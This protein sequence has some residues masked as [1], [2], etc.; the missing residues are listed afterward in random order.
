MTGGCRRSLRASAGY[1]HEFNYPSRLDEPET[2]RRLGTARAH[3]DDLVIHP[4]VNHFASGLLDH[5]DDHDLTIAGG[6]GFEVGRCYFW[7]KLAASG[8]G[9]ER[10]RVDQLLSA[11]F[12]DVPAG[13][14][15]EALEMW[16]T[17]LDDE[18]P[19]DLDWRDRLYLEQRL[20]AWWST[21]NQTSDLIGA[22]YFYPANSLWIFARLLDHPPEAR[23]LGEPQKRVIQELSPQLARVPFNEAA[24]SVLTKSRRKIRAWRR[25]TVSK[26]RALAPEA[27][28]QAPTGPSAA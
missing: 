26:A 18:L 4:L 27:S 15:S 20:G 22:S 21:L 25:G 3:M 6:G 24:D 13:P 11:F 19:L 5:A 16:L 14:W 1:S 23:S 28:G 12:S 2:S 10:P 9:A 17:T 8:L 7:R